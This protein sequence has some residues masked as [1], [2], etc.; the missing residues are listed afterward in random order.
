MNAIKKP[1]K[2]QER[3]PF[4]RQKDNLVKNQTDFGHSTYIGLNGLFVYCRPGKKTEVQIISFSGVCTIR[5]IE[6]R[7]TWLDL[8]IFFN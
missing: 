6:K 8:N 4:K 1:W 7:Y 3:V 2:S 5:T